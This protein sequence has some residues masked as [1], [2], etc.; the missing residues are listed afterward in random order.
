M[1]DLLSKSW[2]LLLIP[3]V[4]LAFFLGAYF[5]FY[6][7]SYEPPARV[8]VPLENI[9][10]P[11]S[12]FEE[13]TDAPAKRRGLLLVDRAHGNDFQKE[14]I[15]TLV[16]RVTDRGFA[17]E[18]IGGDGRF[19]R[20][21]SVSASARLALLQDKLRRADSLVVILPG[22]PYTAEEADLVEQFV[23]KGGKLL[24]I[25]DPSREHDINSLGKRFG[26]AFQPDYLYNVVEHDLNFQDI[27]V[28]SFVPDE[29]TRGLGG[30]ALYAA[31][32]I[33]TSGKI[34]AA[35]DA[36]TRSSIAE[37][38]ETYYPLARA[39]DGHVLALSDLT[40]M[41]PP[42]NSVL[43]NARLISNIADFLTTSDRRFELADFPFF[44]GGDVDI[45]LGRPTL[46]DTATAL[47]S[48]LSSLLVASEIRGVEDLTRDSVHIGLYPD[49]ASVVQYLD[50]AGIEV[51][52]TLRTPFTP[53]IPTS[54]TALILLHRNGPRNVLIVLAHS[55][56]ALADMVQRLVLGDFR[57]GL[58]SD[59]LGVYTSR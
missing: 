6:R 47:K 46:F 1:L 39:S 7:G 22:D 44:F 28:R 17:V 20:F 31:G 58:V 26:I 40:F 5:L 45:L 48:A 50:V 54:G 8:Q 4:A 30:I 14:E 37:R 11:S 19:G 59:F 38:D 36:N 41:V 57:S 12:A 16:S 34:L 43:D 23:N 18:F 49:A 3:G 21:A 25:A 10:V 15:G 35:T 53:D 32:S 42:Q 9:R 24:L 33:K 29:V 13:F 55:E 27:F 51:S 2:R 52:G 56:R